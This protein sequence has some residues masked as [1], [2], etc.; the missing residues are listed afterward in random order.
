M[1]SCAIQ[2][3]SQVKKCQRVCEAEGAQSLLDAGLKYMKMVASLASLEATGRIH[4]A[5]DESILYH[6]LTQMQMMRSW[7]MN[8]LSC[9]LTDSQ[10]SEFLNTL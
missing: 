3:M 6:H 9:Q 1:L 7:R 4:E 5:F 10:R 2:R 8:K